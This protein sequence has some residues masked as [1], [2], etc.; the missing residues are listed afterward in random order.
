MPAILEIGYHKWLVRDEAAAVK[1]LKAL[2]D[3]VLVEYAWEGTKKV[4]FPEKR[5]RDLT[6]G[7]EIIKAS[8]LRREAPPEEEEP[9]AKPVLQLP[10]KTA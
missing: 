5:D 3:A 9:K 6:I 4:Y 2:S 10:F 8:Q 1:A 7:L